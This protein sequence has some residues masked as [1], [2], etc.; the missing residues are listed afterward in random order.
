M[1]TNQKRITILTADEIANLYDCPIFNATE[2]EEY[3]ALD[4]EILMAVNALDKFETKL[5]LMLLI[6]Y[7][8]AKPVV[9]QFTLK[10]AKQDVDYLCRVYF[11]DKKP[12]Y[13]VVIQSTRTKLVNKM[14]ALLDFERFDRRK[15]QDELINRL[16][17]IATICS[18]PRY[19]FDEYLA[20]FGQKRIALTGYST[21]QKCITEV[22]IA[23]RQRAESVFSHH[24]SDTTQ[25][26]LRNIMNSKGVLNKLSSY[27]GR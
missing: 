8:R 24:M 26:Q 4:D 21:A 23:E 18:D 27:K 22:L 14:L 6:G 3:F 20:F 10:T 1:N 16:Q 7:F 9:P 15:H 12:K 19:I 17:D 13:G 2:R 11:P 5:Y 25:Q